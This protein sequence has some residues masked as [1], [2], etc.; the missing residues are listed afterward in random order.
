MLRTYVST[1][2]SCDNCAVVERNAYLTAHSTQTQ[3]LPLSSSRSCKQH[4]VLQAYAAAYVC[5]ALVPTSA[6]LN[7]R[8][9]APQPVTERHA[10]TAHARRHPPD[11]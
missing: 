7:A 1:D 5:N 9:G 3:Q 4:V 6:A 2:Y 10:V 11:I 8:G